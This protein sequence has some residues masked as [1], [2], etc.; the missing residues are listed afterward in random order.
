MVG[1]VDVKKSCQLDDRIQVGLNNMQERENKGQSFIEQGAIILEVFLFP[2]LFIYFLIDNSLVI[3]DR[4]LP[5]MVQVL[6]LFNNGQAGLPEC[7]ILAQLAKR[8]IL[9][10][11]SVVLLSTFV[12]RKNLLQGP[13]SF[14]EITLPMLM[15][16]FWMIFNVIGASRLTVNMMPEPLLVWTSVV[17]LALGLVGW[18]ICLIS[19][20]N[21]RYS[22]LTYG[23]S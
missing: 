17:G 16:F 6:Q 13:N 3:I 15:T 21:L 11:F 8:V 22:L 18:I 20:Y 4:Q 1:A 9:I 19:I 14:R 12:L 23:K 10:M 5:Q 2:P 7:V